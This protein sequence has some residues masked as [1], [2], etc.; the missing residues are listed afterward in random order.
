MTDTIRAKNVNGEISESDV[1]FLAY[2]FAFGVSGS[3]FDWAAQG[4][5]K[6]P[7]ELTQQVIS[8]V[9]DCENLALHRYIPGKDM[10]PRD[11]NSR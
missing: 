11:D 2:F 7:E 4:M 3:I 5:E 9:R 1:L 10:T 6:T 8:V